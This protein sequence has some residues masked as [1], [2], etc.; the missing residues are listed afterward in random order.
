M[1]ASGRRK[2]ASRKAIGMRQQY[3]PSIP[4]FQPVMLFASSF[5]A[6]AMPD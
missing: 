2:K 4:A 6:S 3:A 1:N 5:L